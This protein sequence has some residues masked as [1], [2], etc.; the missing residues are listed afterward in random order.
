MANDNDDAGCLWTLLGAALLC[1]SVAAL[2]WAWR[3]LVWTWNWK[4]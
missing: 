4:T 2:V 1:V 3:F